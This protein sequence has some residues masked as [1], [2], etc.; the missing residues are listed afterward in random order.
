M[1]NESQSEGNKKIEGRLRSGA[2]MSGKMN[3][4]REPDT[5]NVVPRSKHIEI[6]R[7]R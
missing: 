5:R 6:S 3:D 1:E 7:F 2:N 4:R